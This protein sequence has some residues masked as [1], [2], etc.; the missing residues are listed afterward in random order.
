[1]SLK[2]CTLSRFRPTL[3]KRGTHLTE[4]SLDNPLH[5]H[6]SA[7]EYIVICFGSPG[8][9]SS[10]RPI[11]P[12]LKG[13][14]QQQ[15]VTFKGASLSNFCCMAASKLGSDH[16]FCSIYLVF[17]KRMDYSKIIPSFFLTSTHRRVLSSI[18][19][20]W[21]TIYFWSSYSVR[22]QFK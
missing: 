11:S 5:F 6:S 20:S 22:V 19:S 17:C 8:V 3:S 4:R 18:K 12:R 2:I 13:T 15:I 7:T 10:Q 9:S 1:M 14:I 16:L 21:C